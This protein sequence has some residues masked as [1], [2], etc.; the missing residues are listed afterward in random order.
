IIFEI[1]ERNVINDIKGFKDSIT[2]YKN[3]G[4]QIAI[5]DAGS[6][7]AGLN[8][9]SDINPDYIKLDIN[10]I[11]DIDKDNLK[12]ALVKS[13]VEFSRISNIKLI[14]EGIETQSECETLIK[15]GVQFGQGY[16]IQRP[17]E[18]F[19]DLK[20]IQCLVEEIN[21]K[22]NYGNHYGI[23]STYISHLCSKTT[24]VDP[25]EK[26]ISVYHRIKSNESKIGF[27]VVENEV[28]IGI[29]TKGDLALKLS[30]NYG[31]TL[32]SNH[33]IRD[34]MKTDFMVV[35][36]IMPIEQVSN[37][38]MNRNSEELYDFIVV[39]QEGKYLGTVTVKDLLQKT[40]E[41]QIISAKQQN[42]LTGLPGNQLIEQKMM[43]CIQNDKPY[44]IIYCDID[45][46]KVYN[47][48]YGFE[49]GDL[50]IKMLSDVLREHTNFS[51][52]V[53]HIGG[54]DFV[55]ILDGYVESDFCELLLHTF[56]SRISQFYNALDLSKGYVIST[57]REG[58]T[59]QFP[60]LSL[61]SVMINNRTRIFNN[62][63][64]ISQVLANL[65]KQEK[66]KNHSIPM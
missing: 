16:F 25:N 26:T 66:Q 31:F 3:Q 38:A 45:H 50:I 29:V 43:S 19:I 35:E 55:V 28:P 56:V 47:D 21:Q 24:C 6:G 30:G 17:N 34:L 2:H 8:L 22:N 5:D 49:N 65:K 61:T 59:K 46:F 10:L 9:I 60:L 64:E 32:F 54:D 12:Y 20:Q 52:F 4:F 7:Y 1:T 42:P 14:A 62:H 15:L 41:L 13:M 37:L 44:T 18:L 53:G 27:C 40:T 33:T 39:V 23:S 48:I 11:R 36:A 63:Y 51:D 58:E 57:N